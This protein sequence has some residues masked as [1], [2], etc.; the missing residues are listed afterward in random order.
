M[1]DEEIKERDP[2]ET[3]PDIPPV[4]PPPPIPGKP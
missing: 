2:D 4:E 3:I 1:R